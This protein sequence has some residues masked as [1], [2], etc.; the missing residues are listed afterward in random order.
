MP[1]KLPAF[2]TVKLEINYASIEGLIKQ[3]EVV[4]EVVAFHITVSLRQSTTAQFKTTSLKLETL[5]DGIATILKLLENGGKNLKAADFVDNGPVQQCIDISTQSRLDRL[6]DIDREPP[7]P[8]LRATLFR[9]RTIL[10]QIHFRQMSDR[11]DEVDVAYK[12]TLEW[13][14]RGEEYELAWSNFPKFLK[15]PS[16]LPY[17]INGKAGSGKSTLL[18]FLIGHEKTIE[19]L[20]AW[21]GTRKLE[22]AHFFSWNLGTVLQKTR[23]GLLQS[24]IYQILVRDGSLIHRVFPDLWHDIDPNQSKVLEPLSLP[25][26]KRAFGK[27]INSTAAHN[28]FCFFIDGVDEFDGDYSLVTDLLLGSWAPNLKLIVSSRPVNICLEKFADCP[29]FRLQDL[30]AD[31][32]KAYIDGRLSSNPAML[33]LM[34]EEP[35]NARQLVHEVKERA[36]GV[37][38]W[39]KL[40]VTSL[41]NGLMEGDDI[42]DLKRRLR[43][44]PRELS[45]LFASMLGRMDP[46]HQ[47]QAA[48]LF[49]LLRTA[50]MLLEGE[51]MPTQFLAVARNEFGSV[52]NGKPVAFESKK[53]VHWCW[54]LMRQL[55]SR[56]CGLVELFAS[57]YKPDW[58]KADLNLL[59]EEDR[60][61]L[62]SHVQFIHRTVAEYLYQ[63]KVWNEVVDK[64]LDDT[65]FDPYENL[66][67]ASLHMMKVSPLADEDDLASMQAYHWA[68]MLVRAARKYE[69]NEDKPL[70]CLL[71]EMDLVLKHH[72]GRPDWPSLIEIYPDRQVAIS[73]LAVLQ[74]SLTS[75]LSFTTFTGLSA[76]VDSKLH[77]DGLAR[78]KDSAQQLM[79]Q[80]L[81]SRSDDWTH[82]E[83]ADKADV[84]CCLL[85]HGA[86]PNETFEGPS[87]WQCCLQQLRALNCR[88]SD[89]S[90]KPTSRRIRARRRINSDSGRSLSNRCTCSPQDLTT[91]ANIVVVCLKS[92]AKYSDIGYLTPV[93]TDLE[94]ASLCC[95]DL[96]CRKLHQAYVS[97]DD[98][99]H[100]PQ[101]EV[102]PATD[103]PSCTIRPSELEGYFDDSGMRSTAKQPDDRSVARRASKTIAT[104]HAGNTY[105]S[106]VIGGSAQV[107]L[108]DHYVYNTYHNCQPISSTAQGRTGSIGVDAKQG[109]D[110]NLPASSP[111]YIEILDNFYLE[112]KTILNASPFTGRSNNQQPD[113]QK[114]TPEEQARVEMWHWRG[115]ARNFGNRQCGNSTCETTTT[116]G[117]DYVPLL[118]L[119]LCLECYQWWQKT[120]ELRLEAKGRDVVLT[121]EDLFDQTFADSVRSMEIDD[122]DESDEE[123]MYEDLPSS[124]P[125][126]KITPSVVQSYDSGLEF[127]SAP[128]SLP[129][130]VKKAVST[131]D[132]GMD[133]ITSGT[134]HYLR[135]L[136][137]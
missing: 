77:S 96:L 66:A 93:D 61:L 81:F 88:R 75:F 102:A 82:I 2:A 29:Q 114:L 122:S 129:V 14:F 133:S 73:H 116:A 32:I 40:V 22:I 39:V 38:L 109:A 47:T 130:T 52:L 86:S 115:D 127:F 24:L 37:F 135:S 21:S 68:K 3:L 80:A 76:F 105:G 112:T 43:K 103:S 99:L 51:G 13:I 84:V 118:K 110:D 134:P 91:W 23:L 123:T 59:A 49:R 12:N 95:F 30:T 92:G 56:C 104:N 35:D 113:P 72:A 50:S 108:G 120:G 19:N 69:R 25:E 124:A 5:Q 6:H 55:Q 17:W 98:S 62:A 26:A 131:L 46:D 111:D 15:E 28:S 87:F 100:V 58:W 121:G 79:I 41:L 90:N 65:T 33:N 53:I 4:C 10:N 11:I 83:L 89:V 63:D 94:A 119:L 57:S 1:V 106:A 78:R 27:M 31:D 44:L 64:K 128:Q 117:W 54:I 137:R 101:S 70:E 48:T 136:S 34:Q 42:N 71:D 97:N 7:S 85:E 60:G 74:R 20:K 45:K 16:P 67:Y 9:R 132:Y 18:R 8:A 125:K 126:V 107:H 36:S